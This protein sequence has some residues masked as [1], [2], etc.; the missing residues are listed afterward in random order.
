MP[1]FGC[2]SEKKDIYRAENK[3]KTR[4][5][6][7]NTRSQGKPMHALCIIMHALMFITENLVAFAWLIL[8]KMHALLCTEV[9]EHRS[10]A[11]LTCANGA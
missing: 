3:K 1:S 8:D 6:P 11:P 9:R 7:N 5:K 2:F 4:L 10:K